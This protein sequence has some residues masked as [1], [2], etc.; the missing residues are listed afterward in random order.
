MFALNPKL[1]HPQL[2]FLY[3]L[4]SS[5]QQIYSSGCPPGP[6]KLKIQKRS[7]R[8]TVSFFPSFGQMR[9]NDS[10][11]K[12]LEVMRYIAFFCRYGGFSTEAG[13]I[14]Q[15]WALFKA[16]KRAENKR[17]KAWLC[18]ADNWKSLERRSWHSN[19]SKVK[20]PWNV[21]DKTSSIF[22]S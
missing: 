8:S 20:G 19:G 14:C 5:I 21:H 3:S 13:G 6:T 11:G 15:V 17:A 2:W 4:N 12:D 1:G 22:L 9:P 18:F 10:Q 16:R 7:S